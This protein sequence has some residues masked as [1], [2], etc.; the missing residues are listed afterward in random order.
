ML[1]RFILMFILLAVPAMLTL[2]ACT[3]TSPTVRREQP[4]WLPART[5]LNDLRASFDVPGL[6]LVGISQCSPAPPINTGSATLVPES[7]VADTTLFEA[8]SLSK[9]VFAYVVMRLFDAGVIDL[10]RPLAADFQYSR[11]TD[12][13][14]YQML[15]T[16]LILSH[17]T[18]LPNWVGDT[19]NQQRTD[20][21]AFMTD[22]GGTE[23]YSGEAYELLRAY[24]EFKTG[25]SLN[26]LFVRHLGALMPHSSF[27]PS[28][29]SPAHAALGY[30]S[31]RS[32][33][34]GR[35]IAYLGGAAGGLATTAADYANFLGLICRREGLSSKAYAQMF[36]PQTQI[37]TGDMPGVGARALG[38]VVLRMGPRTLILH[39]GNNREFRS[40]AGFDAETGDGFVVLTNGLNGGDLIAAIL[41]K[42]Q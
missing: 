31:A 7:P 40:F 3:T 15:T 27:A 17:R 36:T 23:S 11:I 21:I 25:M 19:D 42:V 26:E 9:P 34:N 20:T 2:S 6:A 24:V 16:R 35:N 22:P 28:A 1:R 29:R 5:Q 8:A 12:A 10:D 14:R 38:W 39:D 4:G 41:E 32:P 13:R 30:A 37:T 18:G 33:A